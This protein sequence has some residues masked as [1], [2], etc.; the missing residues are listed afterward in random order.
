MPVVGSELSFKHFNACLVGTPLSC[1]LA[2]VTKASRCP[3]SCKARI[4]ISIINN[5]HNRFGSTTI[6]FSGQ[7]THFIQF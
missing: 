1:V 2:N 4:D 3:A 5:Y 7:S 6:H